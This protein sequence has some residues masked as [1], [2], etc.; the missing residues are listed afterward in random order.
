MHTKMHTH[1]QK[2]T[3]LI[4]E[5]F[6]VFLRSFFESRL[7]HGGT[8]LESFWKTERWNR[9]SILLPKA[10]LSNNYLFNRLGRFIFKPGLNITI[11]LNYGERTFGALGSLGGGNYQRLLAKQWFKDHAGNLQRPWAN[12]PTNLR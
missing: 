6:W 1:T 4:L 8:I 12:G 7:G 9:L 2:H 10:P 11:S 3:N 5:S